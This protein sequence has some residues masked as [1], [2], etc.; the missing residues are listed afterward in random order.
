M[1]KLSLGLGL[2]VGY[3][4]GARAGRARF[5]QI[6]GAAGSLAERPEV[7]QGLEKLKTAVP[8]Q[9]QKTVEN[10]SHR[11]SSSRPA[12]SSDA[13]VAGTPASSSSSSGTVGALPTDAL[14]PPDPFVPPG[15]SD[16]SGSRP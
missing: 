2:A 10:L 12:G 7:Q 3:V 16:G 5:E 11:T 9:L 13:G 6:K 14:K 1:G 4:I 8:P 15:Q